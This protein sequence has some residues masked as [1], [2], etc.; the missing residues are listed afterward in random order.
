MQAPPNRFNGLH[1][2]TFENEQNFVI[3]RE[4]MSVCAALDRGIT[5]LRYKK[6]FQ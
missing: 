2:A 4:C 3:I 6:L 1:D 5:N